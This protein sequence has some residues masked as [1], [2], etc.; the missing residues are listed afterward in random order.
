MER[1]SKLKV[2][3]KRR[4]ATN[5]REDGDAQCL[6]VDRRTV[7]KGG[8]IAGAAAIITSR[9]S[10]VFAQG[11]PEPP[12]SLGEPSMCDPRPANSPPT[13]PF[14]DDLPIPQPAFPTF[15]HPFPTKK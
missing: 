15:L 7:V 4:A 11:Y 3:S 6:K 9:K 5:P 1:M 8:V 12:P 10:S 13:T 14:V 2:R